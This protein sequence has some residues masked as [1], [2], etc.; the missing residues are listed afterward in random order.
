[1]QDQA[2]SRAH[3]IG[4]VREVRVYKLLVENS[5]EDSIVKV[6]GPVHLVDIF[7]AEDY[8]DA[9]REEGGNRGPVESVHGPGRRRDEEVAS[10]RGFVESRACRALPIV[11]V[12]CLL[13]LLRGGLKFSQ[14]R[15]CGDSQN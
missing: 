15:R 7:R 13:V 9:G 4:Q 2:I 5:I 10:L 12:S 1:M 11:H 8:L 6:C 14:K 3:R